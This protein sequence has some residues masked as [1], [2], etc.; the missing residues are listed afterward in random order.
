MLRQNFTLNDERASASNTKV[1]TSTNVPE[2]REKNRSNKHWYIYLTIGIVIG[3]VVNSTFS[4]NNSMS[5]QIV[6]GQEPLLKKRP[7][8]IFPLL[9][10]LNSGWKN[11][12]VPPLLHKNATGMGALVIDVGLDKGNEFFLAIDNGFEVVG[13]EPNPQSFPNLAKKCTEKPKC[14]IVDLE[15]APLPLQREAGHSYLINAGAA[16]EKAI[17]QFSMAHDTSSFVANKGLSKKKKVDVPVVRIDDIIR[18][19][20]YLFKVDT[21]GYD[22]FVIE[23]ATRSDVKKKKHC[24]YFGDSVEGFEAVFDGKPGYSHQWADCF[25]DF[26][27]LN[28]EK[29][30]PGKFPESLY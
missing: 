21:Q 15:K 11:L 12:Q 2:C 10:E 5:A 16:S 1:H 3:T 8:Q 7:L 13:F 22:Q 17:L 4:Y 28:T 19:D 24:R 25:E 30:Y 29:A 20:V 27:C 26:L 9:K 23:G 6:L 18:D 14:N